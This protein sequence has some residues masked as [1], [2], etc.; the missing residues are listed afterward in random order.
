M[1][2]AE[3]SRQFYDK[4][5]VLPQEKPYISA[6]SKVYAWQQPFSGQLSAPVTSMH[7]GSRAAHCR[8]WPPTSLNKDLCSQMTKWSLYFLPE[9]RLDTSSGVSANAASP[10][11]Q[12]DADCDAYVKEKEKS[13][14]LGVIME[15]AVYRGSPGLLFFEG[16]NNTPL[17]RLDIKPSMAISAACKSKRYLCA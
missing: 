1:N 16:V 6:C 8:E 12:A 15:A 4:K 10:C 2:I 11:I 7:V 9:S 3:K 13:T 5:G 14:L 17:K